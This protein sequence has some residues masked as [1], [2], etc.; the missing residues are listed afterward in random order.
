MSSGPQPS[1]DEV[2]D[3]EA[4]VDSSMPETTPQP[5]G[6]RTL[7]SGRKSNFTPKDDA[8]LRKLV[9]IHG[10]TKRILIASIM[11]KWNRKQLRDHYINF[12]K[13]KS[14]STNFSSEE[15][16]YI[17]KSVKTHGHAWK[18]IATKLPGRSPIAIKNRFYKKLLK[19]LKNVKAEKKT[20][21]EKMKNNGKKELSEGCSTSKRYSG[22]SL[23]Q[24]SFEIKPM[25]Q[26]KDEILKILETI[27]NSIDKLHSYLKVL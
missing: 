9:K 19:R 14:I 24:N 17:L 16:A 4:V 26:I 18:E 8:E 10:E 25:V 7:K 2:L 12:I 6:G 1:A 13:N 15:D 23:I 5:K 27:N 20:E 11:T 3:L 21:S 22:S